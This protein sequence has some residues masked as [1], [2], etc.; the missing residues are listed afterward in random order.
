MLR[1]YYSANG[2]KIRENLVFDLV[3]FIVYNM[4]RNKDWMIVMKSANIADLKSH[5]SHFLSLVQKG[6]TVQVCKRNVPVA[7][8]VPERTEEKVINRT[9]LGC[10]RNTGR[11]I[12]DL[13]EPAIPA[14]DWDMLSGSGG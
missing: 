5:F 1:D 10:A 6:E 7:K 8:F 2:G 13:T 11:I 4:K 14:E 12:G 3:M 9:R